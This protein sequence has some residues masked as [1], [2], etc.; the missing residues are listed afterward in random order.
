MASRSL[1]MDVLGGAG[2][3]TDSEIDEYIELNK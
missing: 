3:L 2:E 1:G